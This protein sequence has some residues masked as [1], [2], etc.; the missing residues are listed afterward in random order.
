MEDYLEAIYHIIKDGKV[1]RSKDIS[2]ALNVAKPSV[3]G[4]LKVLSDKGLVNYKPYGYVTLT[5]SGEEQAER[6]VKK[7][8]AIRSFFENVLGV[9]SKTAG[10]AACKA[11]HSLGPRIISRLLSF[12]E[13]VQKNT[14]E[15]S[16]IAENFH[17]YYSEDQ[18]T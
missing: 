12:N 14:G 6:V 9:D 11:E 5:T 3:T 18:G 1:A 15:R 17:K 16:A 2:E 8:N 4:A 10:E 7:H 13:F